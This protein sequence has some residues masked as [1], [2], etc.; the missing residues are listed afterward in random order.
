MPTLA[1]TDHPHT[2]EHGDHSHSH[3]PSPENYAAR[4]H[5]EFVV[6]DIGEHI[7]ALIIQ[8]DPELHGVEIE[9]SLEGQDKSRSHKEVLERDAGGY[10]AFTAVFDGLAEGRYTLWVNDEARARGVEIEGGSIAQLD[11]RGGS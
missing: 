1:H 2:H 8:T 5:P 9:I 11:W 6:L 3:G 10:P 4:K 7:G